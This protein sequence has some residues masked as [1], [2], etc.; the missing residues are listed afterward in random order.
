VT[1]YLKH[2]PRDACKCSL[3]G[4]TEDIHLL[5]GILDEEGDDTGKIACIKCYP[6]DGDPFHTGWCCASPRLIALSIAPSLK[7]FYDQWVASYEWWL[8]RRPQC[9]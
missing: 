5:D 9:A 7:P 6:H 8:S 1:N 3:C 4:I 2:D